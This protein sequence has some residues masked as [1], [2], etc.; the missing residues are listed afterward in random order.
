MATRGKPRIGIVSVSAIPDDPR[1]RRQGDL[2]VANGWDVVA[3]GVGQGSSPLPLWPYLAAP[4]R[5]SRQSSGFLDPSKFAERLRR[6]FGIMGVYLKSEHASKLFWQLAPEFADM[7]R[8]AAAQRADIWLANDWTALPIVERLAGEQ[9]VPYVYDTHELALDEY[10][11]NWRWRLFQRPIVAALEGRGIA[12]AASVSCVSSGIAAHLQLNYRLRERPLVIRNTPAYAAFPFREPGETIRVLYHG[13]VTP[14]RGL[15]DCIRSV[16]HWKAG[17]TFSIIGPGS[18]EYL[19]HLNGIMAVES[20]SDRVEL[21]PPVNMVD[22]VREASKFDIGLFAL[23]GHS[24]QNEYVLPNKFFEY[25]MAGLALC[26]S[27][28]PEMAELISQYQMGG[29]I[30]EV[31]PQTIADAINCF[32][33][34]SIAACKKNSLKAAQTL[35]WEA[36]ASRLLASVAHAAG[37]QLD[38]QVAGHAL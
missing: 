2:F 8:I 5:L 33:R 4:A 10:Q 20:V 19:K 9:G 32:D 25:A 12:K 37:V 21:L 13:L 31:T 18:K 29:L 34:E 28:L 24:K 16:R 14:G 35:N 38:S 1:V 23:P 22:L 3:V 11:H 15:E 30:K 27:D 6:L 36:E 7:Y 26:V 17:Y